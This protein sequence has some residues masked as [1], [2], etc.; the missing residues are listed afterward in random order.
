MNINDYISISKK[1]HNQVR[2]GGIWYDGKQL[3]C[4]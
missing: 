3:S 1:V 4:R 2:K